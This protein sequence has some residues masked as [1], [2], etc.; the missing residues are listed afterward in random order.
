MNKFHSYSFNNS[1]LIHMQKPNASYVAGYKTWETMERHV[2]KDEKGI[3]ILAP[4]PYKV[5]KP[6]EVIDPKTG[7]VKRDIHVS[8][9]PRKEK[10]HMPTLKQFPFSIFPRQRVNHFQ[11]W[12]RSYKVKYRITWY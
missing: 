6:V 2:R 1:M 8:L 12:H 3:K 4:C 7:Q 11:N 10:S 9:S 5:K